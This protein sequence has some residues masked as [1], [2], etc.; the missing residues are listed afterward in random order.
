M[1]LQTFVNQETCTNPNSLDDNELK[2]ALQLRGKST[3]GARQT[4]INRYLES[5]TSTV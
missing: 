2:A 1:F 5:E 4:L 3:S